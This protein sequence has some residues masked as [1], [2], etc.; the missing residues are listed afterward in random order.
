M[1]APDFLV[2]DPI[3]PLLARRFSYVEA[4][5]WGIF[6]FRKTD[7]G[8]HLAVV[9]DRIETIQQNLKADGIDNVTLWP[10]E[11]DE[12]EATLARVWAASEQRPLLP[13]GEL[14]HKSGLVTTQE[15]RHG[16]EIVTKTQQPLAI[17]LMQEI[18]LKGTAIARVAA[19]H[20]GYPLC[21][22]PAP[23][24]AAAKPIVDQIK[25]LFAEGNADFLLEHLLLPLCQAGRKVIVASA[26]PTQKSTF[27]ALEATKNWSLEPVV[28]DCN[29]LL[30]W[31]E[32]LASIERKHLPC[33]WPSEYL[34]EQLWQKTFKVS[35][36]I[37]PS[38]EQ[39]A[40]AQSSLSAPET[41]QKRFGELL[42]E[43]KLIHPEDLDQALQ[44]Q[45]KQGGRIGQILLSKNLLNPWQ[46]A[47]ILS[48]QTG[49]PLVKLVEEK[50]EGSLRDKLDPH[51]FAAMPD[52]FWRQY[53]LVPLQQAHGQMQV[54][55]VDPT[56]EEA[57]Y[58]LTS[59]T[60]WKIERLVTGFRD[61]EA[62]LT[63]IYSDAF[64]E[65]ARFG[66]LRRDP[67]ESASRTL[68]KMQV[69]GLVGLIAVMVGG[70]I[71]QG[72]GEMLQ[73]ANIVSQLLFFAICI[74]KLIG[75]GQV[76][77]R[78]RS[79]MT[80]SDIELA[81]LA[82]SSLPVYTVLV[83]AYQEAEILP[84]LTDAL[85]ALHYPHDR[86]DVKL[87][88][89]ASDHAT[90]EVARSLG[91]PNFI[92]IV[93]V[94]DSDPKTKPKACN[95]GLALARGTYTTILDAED[96]PEADELLK[97]VIA[98]RKSPSDVA[99]VQ[100]KLA[101]YNRRQNLLT[102]WFTAE[103]LQWFDWMLPALHQ[104][105]MPIP[106][107]GTSNHFRTDVLRE[108]G[109]WDPFNVAEDADLGM[110]L[111]RKGWKTVIVDATTYEEANSEWFN[112]I[113]QRSRWVKGYM[114][115][116]LV[117]MRHPLLLYKEM[118]GRGFWGVQLILFGTPFSFLVTPIF[119][120]LTSLWWLMQPSWITFLFPPWI[121]FIS[122]FNMLWGG[123]FFSYLNL[124][125]AARRDFWELAIASLFSVIYWSMMSVA[126]WRA[127]WQLTTKPSYWEKTEHGLAREFWTT[128]S[129]GRAAS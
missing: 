83:P 22:L 13:L 44:Q 111:H 65:E 1:H 121:Y 93:V 40:A 95:Y 10:V 36:P 56:D 69:A 72:T 63:Y 102:R 126:A 30:T 62:A 2:Q 61:V 86:L 41:Q 94:P 74:G 125:A 47:F 57:V 81:E 117:H 73:L 38:T 88:L 33:W 115:T 8:I 64:S 70:A 97:A 28:A 120:G 7:S 4:Q 112:W 87:L 67:E 116:W 9:A 3:D 77:F 35:E 124:F 92:E 52:A 25:L 54:A 85:K 129:A 20:T 123:F 26:D 71:V 78:A 104:M 59:A 58:L 11:Q 110:R 113:R 114:Q 128:D 27:A 29:D 53:L 60:G 18:G 66:L 96:I 12:F 24:S 99:C 76:A 32:W 82:W 21:F 101:Y 118:G 42:L 15:L 107:G 34:S 49:F 6:P 122:V 5:S 16:L 75:L 45:Q 14:L 19:Y 103:Y 79:G 109:A 51:L 89:E 23:D 43:A 31:L 98:F 127:L 46:V 39:I 80:I 84:T 105:K 119:W 91:L 108:V 50:D 90:L 106:L 17:A 37:S 55:M 100:A 68:S 48:Q